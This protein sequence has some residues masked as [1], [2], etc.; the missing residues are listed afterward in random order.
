M[1]TLTVDEIIQQCKLVL[2]E[3][4]GEK[5]QGTLLYGSSARGDSVSDSDIDLLILLMPPFD[6][7]AE[8][9]RIV[10]LLYPI[11]LQSAQLISA[12]PAS[13]KDFEIGSISLYRNIQAEGV[14][15]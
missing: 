12:K 4:Y 1:D 11:Q 6:F 13:V 2:E 5:L 14:A 3:Y 7:F 15:V 10:D 9:R 8:L